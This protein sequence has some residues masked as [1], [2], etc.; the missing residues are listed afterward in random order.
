MSVQ[1]KETY[2]IPLIAGEKQIQSFQ[3]MPG[4]GWEMGTEMPS[5]G[6]LQGHLHPMLPSKL[7]QAAHF[8]SGVL[9][10]PTSC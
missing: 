5:S 8:R 3:Y 7:L 4:L 1:N 2:F 6:F 10:A 9:G